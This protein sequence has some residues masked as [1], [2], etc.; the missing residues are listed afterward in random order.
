MKES[1]KAIYLI[2]ISSVLAGISQLLWKKASFDLTSDPLSLLNV[3]LIT[4]AILYVI[5]TFSMTFAFK[6]GELSTLMPFLSL[7]YIW[8]VLVST[9]IFTTETLNTL[10]FVAVFLVFAGVYFIGKGGNSNAD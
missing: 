5:A 1:K 7:S 9:L 2:L 10:R 4:G 8:V 3:F 6:R